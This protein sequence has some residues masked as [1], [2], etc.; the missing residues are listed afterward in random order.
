MILFCKTP[1]TSLNKLTS[2][3]GFWSKNLIQTGSCSG[4]KNSLPSIVFSTWKAGVWWYDEGWLVHIGIGSWLRLYTKSQHIWWF[5]VERQNHLFKSE[6][7]S[8]KR[9]TET[10][11]PVG[12]NA[13]LVIELTESLQ[14]QLSCKKSKGGYKTEVVHNGWW[15]AFHATIS[16]PASS[17]EGWKSFLWH[18]IPLAGEHTP[19]TIKAMPY[20]TMVDIGSVHL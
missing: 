11:F 14:P 2:C 18:L 7:C 13:I 16:H 4:T 15:R 17:Y 5:G 3:L 8:A 6:R 19:N 20:A 10:K 1:E 12:P 9:R